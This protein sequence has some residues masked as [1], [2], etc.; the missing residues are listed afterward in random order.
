M[1]TAFDALHDNNPKTLILGTFP[2]IISRANRGYYANPQ[3]QFWRI[4]ANAFNE[5]IDFNDY[6][7]KK[8]MI[9]R[10]GIALWDT[11]KSCNVQGSLDSNIKNEVANLEIPDFV[12]QFN[13]SKIL[14][15]GN[16]A[17]EFYRR[18]IGVEHLSE[19]EYHIMPS[20]SPANA[21]M[22]FAQK[23]LI[24]KERLLSNEYELTET[25]GKNI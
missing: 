19:T 3:N 25:A 2:S 20:T 22:N 16:K 23:T 17:Y 12:K 10:H 4:I 11:L 21:K 9:F 24:W 8:A 13:I 1:F 15:N 14:F 7:Q 18:Y 6:G 5:N